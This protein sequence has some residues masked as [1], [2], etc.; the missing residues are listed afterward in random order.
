M[1]VE[2]SLARPRQ[3]QRRTAR[4]RHNTAK[5]PRTMRGGALRIKQYKK[6]TELLFQQFTDIELYRIVAILKVKGYDNMEAFLAKLQQTDVKKRAKE[7]GR[8]VKKCKARVRRLWPIWCFALRFPAY[9]PLRILRE[10][11]RRLGSMTKAALWYPVTLLTQ[12]KFAR[13]AKILAGLGKGLLAFSYNVTAGFFVREY[14]L[15]RQDRK[16]AQ[17]LQTI[18]QDCLTRIAQQLHISEDALKKS[19][20]QELR[21]YREGLASAPSSNVLQQQGDQMYRDAMQLGNQIGSGGR[22]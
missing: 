19:T 4:Q 14:K 9:Y 17:Q 15:S 20:K 11:L 1:E 21:F 6:C 5:K 8:V 16:M 3:R 22:P 2:G 13:N 12:K 18:F 10:T 7:R